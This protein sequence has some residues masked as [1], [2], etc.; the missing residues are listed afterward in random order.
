MNSTATT[1]SFPRNRNHHR[2]PRKAKTMSAETAIKSST[3]ELRSLLS[4]AEKLLANSGDAADEK[5]RELRER[6]RHALAEGHDRFVRL[7]ES[8]RE[9]LDQCDTYVR[10]NPYYAIGAAALVGTIAGIILGR[11]N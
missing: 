10:E 5:V 9:Q 1:S 11:R 7:R 3:E 2:K 4:D 6:L 8:T